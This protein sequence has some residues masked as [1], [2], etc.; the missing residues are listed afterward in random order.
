MSRSYV[1]LT[2]PP[3]TPPPPYEAH[4]NQLL[5]PMETMAFYRQPAQSQQY[6]PVAQSQ[7]RLRKRPS[8]WTST[9]DLSR[10]RNEGR[11]GQELGQQ[12]AFN[13]PSPS[14]MDDCPIARS[15]NQGAALCDRVAAR[16]NEALSRL[17]CDEEEHD[18]VK[19]AI[20]GLTIS[21]ERNAPDLLK[22]NSI[23][24]FKKT[25]H[26]ANSRLPPFLPPMKIFLPTWQI[27]CSAAQASMHVYRR[28]HR[29]ER[30]DYIEADWR[31]GTKAMVVKSRP[32]D[33]ENLIVIAIRGSKWN[34]VDWATNFR[35]APS[36]PVG[37]LDDEGNACHAGFLQVAR[38]M[39]PPI[40]ARLRDL[41][42]QNPSRAS[43]SLLLTGHSAGGAV[44]SLLYMHMLATTFESELNI[45]AGC[46]K[47][48]H[49]VAF[50]TP[51]LTFLPLQTPAGKRY[52]R[53]VFMHFVNEGDLVVRA[54]RQY[55]GT[56]G[57]IIAAPSPKLNLN[58]S[59]GLR[60]KISRHKLSSAAQTAA[61][62]LPCRWEVPPAT[63]SNAGRLVL[64]RETPGKERAVEAVQVTDQQLR[65]VVFGDPDM[66]R[67]DLYKQRVDELASAAITGRDLG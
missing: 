21:G 46:F 3:P 67:M 58:A 27:I 38:A 1:N 47:R 61:Q 11:Y 40:A 9:V 18:Q 20:R 54:D 66:H 65:T 49:C 4:D 34:V 10:Q 13:R 8:A 63:L 31:H 35:P 23:I 26:Y 57:R 45:L 28:P 32:V 12:N 6:L 39:I 50:G 7:H 25:W 14:R 44:A 17:D 48:V 19:E 36:E 15:M 42:E 33:D 59:H 41:I 16:M 43:S 51:P 37:F 22:S 55:L 56:L 62:K 64:L 2:R 5:Q 29:D 24:D 53:N 52:E 30:A 60:S